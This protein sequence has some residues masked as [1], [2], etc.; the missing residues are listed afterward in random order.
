MNHLRAHI[1]EKYELFLSSRIAKKMEKSVYNFTIVKARLKH[2]ELSWKNPIFKMFY[3]FKANSIHFNLKNGTLAE[4]IES[5]E[6]DLAKIPY[7]NSWELWPEKYEDFFQR[8]F[9]KEMIQLKEM[10]DSENISGMFTCRKCKSNCTS[11]FSLQT[12]SADEPMTN[13]ITCKKC[14]YNWKE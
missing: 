7:M 3:K 2:T 6:F 12:R 1:V 5:Y 9:V 8:K 13:Y 10:A 4:K 14:D 11:H